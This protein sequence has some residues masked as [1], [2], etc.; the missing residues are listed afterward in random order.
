MDGEAPNRLG[1]GDGVGPEL[2]V[3][4]RR[5][6]ERLQLDIDYLPAEVGQKPWAEG[7]DP[8]PLP[9]QETLRFADCCLLGALEPSPPGAAAGDASGAFDPLRRLRLELHLF[10]NRRRLQS[11]PGL[12]GHGADGIDLTLFREN[13]EGVHSGIE[14]F[15]LPRNVYDFLKANHAR[16]ERYQATP[17]DEIAI[18]C[19]I[20]TREGCRDIAK[21]AFEEA[22]RL[23]AAEVT[24]IEHP[25]VMRASSGLMIREARRCAGEHPGVALRELA[26]DEACREL[27]KAPTEF[28]VL[29]TTNLFGEMLS[30]LCG[31][32]VGGAGVG[33]EANLGDAFALFRP[34]LQPDAAASGCANPLG[35]FRAV[36]DML[37]WLSESEAAARVAGAVARVVQEGRLRTPD[38]GGDAG[39][40]QVADAVIDA[41]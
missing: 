11:L 15:P 37:E 19:R 39:T 33:W 36:A 32:F 5:L 26:A 8:I 25:R 3:V 41:V 12:P 29:V 30:E 7:G 13:V 34:T 20:V 22:E 35:T 27:Q 9:A 4:A 38:L 40:A 24:V 14:W 17:A 31:E 28:G 18:S 10:T 16:M 21:A 23:G 6:L 2:L 1:P